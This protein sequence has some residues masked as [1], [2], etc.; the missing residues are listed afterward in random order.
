LKKINSYPGSSFYY[1]VWIFAEDLENEV[2]S[3][4]NNQT[5]LQI[6]QQFNNTDE[7][8]CC[9]GEYSEENFDFRYLLNGVGRVVRYVNYDNK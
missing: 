4:K 9:W 1:D 3:K 6:L 8:K 2:I 5:S 7:V